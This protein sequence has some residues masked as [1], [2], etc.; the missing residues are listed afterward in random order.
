[1]LVGFVLDG[2]YAGAI[3]GSGGGGIPGAKTG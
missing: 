2:P 1:M 3:T